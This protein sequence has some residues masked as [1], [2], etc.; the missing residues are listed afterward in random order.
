MKSFSPSSPQCWT[1]ST[2]PRPP[3]HNGYFVQPRSPFDKLF[4]KLFI[5]PVWFQFLASI[6]TFPEV[7]RLMSTVS[8][9]IR[10]HFLKTFAPTYWTS[11]NCLWKPNLEIEGK[12]KIKLGTNLSP[13]LKV[14]VDNRLKVAAKW[15]RKGGICRFNICWKQAGPVNGFIDF[16]L[17]I[18]S[19]STQKW[20]NNF[21]LSDDPCALIF[22]PLSFLLQ[23]E[24]N[25]WSG[26]LELRWMSPWS[27]NTDTCFWAQM[28]EC[29]QHFMHVLYKRLSLIIL[30]L[31]IFDVLPQQVNYL[32][33][34]VSCQKALQSYIIHVEADRENKKWRGRVHWAESSL[35]PKPHPQDDRNG[36]DHRRRQNYD[37]AAFP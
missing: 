20:K 7:L 10:R 24:L 26:K 30:H 27:T 37:R 8:L 29:W 6:S 9:R 22:R 4:D 21:Y 34:V 31:V 11:E 25:S 2:A 19:H 36:K 17:N 12:L 15:N 18:G 23:L 3:T 33:S 14:N 32:T 1:S 35:L 5:F 13:E 16:A 28:K